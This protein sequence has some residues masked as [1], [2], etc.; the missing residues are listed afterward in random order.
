MWDGSGQ[1][2][3]R[4]G[5]EAM[6]QGADIGGSELVALGADCQAASFL[7]VVHAC[8]G[9]LLQ[10]RAGVRSSCISTEGVLRL[11]FTLALLGT[12]LARMGAQNDGTE[13]QS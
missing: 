11:R 4:K 10:R 8:V 12:L 1:R 5:E 13:A 6:E 3:G 9:P 7:E 2:R